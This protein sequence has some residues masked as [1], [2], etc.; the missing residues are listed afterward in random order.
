MS[1]IEKISLK[2]TLRGKI[3][4]ALMQGVL[5][6]QSMFFDLVGQQ[7]GQG[8]LWLPVWLG[9]GIGVYFSLPF[10]P[11]LALSLIVACV[12][13]SLWSLFI[14]IW[15]L[16]DNIYK[17]IILT[18][19]F[20]LSF[21]TGGF[22]LAK[23]RTEMVKAPVIAEE[24]SFAPLEGRIHKLERMEQGVRFWI[25]NLIIEDLEP[26]QTPHMVRLTYKGDAEGYKVGDTIS[27]LASLNPPGAPVLPGGFDFQRHAFFKQIG[28]V[29]FVYKA[30][31]IDHYARGDN[32][33]LWQ[34]LSLG[35]MREAIEARLY[36]VLPER[37]AAIMSALTIGEKRAIAEDDL[38][39]MRESGLA[40]LLA[41]SGLHIGLV[42]GFIFFVARFVMAL[43]P[44]FAV[45][46][47]IKKYAAL[48]A[49]A[50]A[51]F[52]M[53]LAGATI[54]TQRAMLMTGIV[55][56][57][58]LMDRQ[59]ISLRLV[60][61][62]AFVI[63]AFFPEALISASF[64]LSFAAVIGLVAFYDVLRPH[65]RHLYQQSTW[66][67]RLMLYFLGV[68]T[69]SIIATLATTPFA[70][71][72]FGQAPS[73]GI[74]SNV[75]AVPLMAFLIMPVAVLGFVMMPLGLDGPFFMFAGL[76]IEQ[77]LEV[78]HFAHSLPHA[79][80]HAGGWPVSAVVMLTVAGLSLCLCRGRLR[81]ISLPLFMGSLLLIGGQNQYTILTSSNFDLIA[82]HANGDL[83]VNTR[84]K[85][86]F[87]RESWQQ[88]FALNG[89]AVK[90]W[91]AEGGGACDMQCGLHGC[92]FEYHGFS[93]AF[94]YE[95]HA[96]VEDCGWADIL[97]TRF[98]APRSCQSPY[99]YDY[100]SMRKNGAHFMMMD[101]NKVVVQTI[102]QSRGKRPW[103]QS[104]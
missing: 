13:F 44:S 6:V 3:T 68:V 5:R 40:H 100:A 30:P 47:P 41:I 61:V 26:E 65:I 63:L 38:I 58:V 64:H 85:E 94:P 62:A 90:R 31:E 78:A 82:V 77:V 28:A 91:P 104:D 84:S 36:E 15:P 16:S 66:P 67:K 32:Q 4:L 80:Y 71:Y 79:V 57:A 42:S 54:P 88:H 7:R 12:V 96:A 93:I 95:K 9:I 76:G 39:A 73:Y 56:L 55:F 49:M 102:N 81:A 17:R 24:I 35:V 103:V 60:A 29:G 43:F 45:R 19:L 53:T 92:R 23:I 52:Y 101:G 51:L 37:Q 33:S 83:C 21:I 11:P 59:A 10:E 50:G 48:I 75:V 99:I 27:L 97:I 25:T 86:R 70:L 22:S 2:N 69:T 1:W 18:G 34:A 98:S 87:T 89:D 14:G 74:L 8:L 46:H 20:V 72:H